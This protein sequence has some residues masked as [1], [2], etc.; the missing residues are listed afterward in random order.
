MGRMR[1]VG[2]RSAAGLDASVFVVR[3]SADMDRGNLR[4]TEQS[5][6]QILCTIGSQSNWR[7]LAEVAGQTGNDVE[8]RLMRQGPG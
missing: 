7:C 1:G 8:R 4:T 3:C 6:Y 5:R 2:H